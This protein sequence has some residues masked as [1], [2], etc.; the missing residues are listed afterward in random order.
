MTSSVLDSLKMSCGFVEV[1]KNKIAKMGC[2]LIPLLP[3]LNAVIWRQPVGEKRQSLFWKYVDII[4]MK[5]KHCLISVLIILLLRIS[6]V[7]W[8]FHV[9]SKVWVATSWLLMN[10]WLASDCSF[11]NFR[12]FDEYF[13]AMENVCPKTWV[14]QGYYAVQWLR[15]KAHCSEI[16]FWNSKFAIFI[17]SAWWMILLFV[18]LSDFFFQ[19]KIK[20]S[21]KRKGIF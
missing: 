18:Q 6:Y 17:L 13:S 7:W 8:A 5:E 12:L 15:M 1:L 10:C 3:V 21:L 2:F 16:L 11:L 9:I 19:K 14:I 20:T 4:L